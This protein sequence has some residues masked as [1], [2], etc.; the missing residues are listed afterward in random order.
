MKK[1]AAGEAQAIVGDVAEP[2]VREVVADVVTGP[3]ADLPHETSAHGL[4]E[5]IDGL[6]VRPATGRPDEPQVER[7]TDDR[8]GRQDLVGHLPHRVETGAQQ[9]RDT[10]RDRVP[11]PDRRGERFGDIQG[12]A[13]GALEERVDPARL[14]RVAERR[15]GQGC[16]VGPA[17]PL[18]LDAD[19]EAVP[20]GRAE[21]ALA[22]AGR[23]LLRP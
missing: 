9:R 17:E 18:G 4:I 7:T 10:A 5:T 1:A 21:D 16:H 2:A 13:L 19:Q 3:R 22:V 20:G 11:G 6:V 15:R 8:R 14:R 12:Q 23:E